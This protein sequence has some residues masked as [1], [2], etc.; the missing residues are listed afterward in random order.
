MSG[1]R[2]VRTRAL[3][4]PHL[5]R[6]HFTS[7]ARL[8]RV[9]ATR[10]SATRASAPVTRT[11][12][13]L[14]VVVALAGVA[15]CA[16]ADSAVPA[17]PAASADAPSTRAQEPPADTSPFWV[18]P[19]SSAARQV[20]EWTAQG[21]TED[22]DQ[23]KK[24]SERPVANWPA[25]DDP[26][27]DV[28]RAT[29]GASGAGRTA[30]LVAYNIPH[31]DCGQHSAGGAAD[32]D[33][34]RN[35]LDSFASTIG[36]AR[37][38]VILEPD[39]VPHI[40]DGC[41]PAEVHDE[42]SRLLSQSIDRLKQQ[43]GTKVYLDAGNPAW[44]TDPG[45]LVDPLKRAGVEKADGFSL[46]VS[47]FQRDEVVKSYGAQLSGLLGGAHFV[48]DSSRN[49]KG[50]LSGSRTD[51][52]CNPTGRALGKPPTDRT[53]NALLDAYLWIKRPGDSDGQCRG[54]PAAGT[55]WPDYALGLARASG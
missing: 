32:S 20:Q 38:T 45:K 31:R 2:I 47:N 23:L 28:R 37:T 50:P 46:N 5:S 42:R 8:T 53:G 17:A 10:T 55:W 43:P 34:Y 27:P 22:A 25:G 44:I 40:V 26:V 54:G 4:F 16:S 11:S 30:V 1:R 15:G 51:A 3:S 9:S 21:R 35:W 36:N 13:V 24:I 14:A 48:V 6:A 33:A 7:R 18:D 12:L 19:R 49:G 29:A 39:A 52:W 41:T